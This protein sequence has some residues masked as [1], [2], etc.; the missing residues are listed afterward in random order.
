MV[1]RGGHHHLRALTAL[2][3]AGALGC[4]SSPTPKRVQTYV[5][6]VEARV[7][8]AAEDTRFVLRHNPA[9]ECGCPP[10][11]VKLGDRWQRV[12]I[13]GDVEDPV[14]VALAELVAPAGGDP[15]ARD[16]RLFEVEGRL[17][18]EVGLCG[19]GGLYVSLVPT[20][21]VGLAGTGPGGVSLGP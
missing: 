5:D 8:A 18:R 6:R 13:A 16:R 19:R 4:G 17:D 10:F 7:V 2:A 12:E 3:L 21:L 15:S 11:E 1:G 14:I 9:E 20:A